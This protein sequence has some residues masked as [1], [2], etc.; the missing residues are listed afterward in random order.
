MQGVTLHRVLQTLPY[1]VE[2]QQTLRNAPQT[3]QD[4]Y[5]TWVALLT[6]IYAPTS[7]PRANAAD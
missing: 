7:W 1:V 2:V 3:R 4:T 6:I 5:T